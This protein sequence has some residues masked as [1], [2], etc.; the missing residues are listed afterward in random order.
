MRVGAINTISVRWL[1]LA[2]VSLI[3]FFSQIH[4]YIHCY[5]SH[6][7][8]DHPS[9]SDLYSLS[10]T[11][12]PSPNFQDRHHHHGYPEHEG[13]DS[14]YADEEGHDHHHVFNQNIDRHWVRSHTRSILLPIGYSVLFTYTDL[15]HDGASTSTGFTSEENHLPERIQSGSIDSRGP[16]IFS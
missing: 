2:L 16:P 12:G 5:H 15:E 8:Q 3:I 9:T 13:D 14:H 1:K 11:S 10:P 6:H 4:P 7:E